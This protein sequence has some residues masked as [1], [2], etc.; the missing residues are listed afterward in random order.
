MQQADDFLAES[1]SLF[2]L[3][4][5]LDDD[6]LERVTAFK[7]WRIANVIAHLSV[8]NRAAVL[9]L[10]DTDALSALLRGIG[11]HLKAG[12]RMTEFEKDC[13]EGVWGRALVEHWWRSCEETARHFAVADP[14]QR[15]PWAGP[16]MS[17]RSSISARL[18]ETWAHGQEVFDELGVVRANADRIYNIA[19]LGNNTYGWTFKNRGEQPPEPRPFLELVAPS[20]KVWTFNEPRDDERISGSAEAFCQVVTQVRNIADTDLEVSGA[21]AEAWMSRA[22]CFAGAPN[23]PPAPG[24]RVIR[25]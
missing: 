24:T 4:A 25:C 16:D 17:A 23:D 21:N 7:G 12:G 19:V 14:A 1:R 3:V 11:E 8:W 10:T 18:M 6:A 5:P 20:G 9:S 15:V 22:Q 13:H 2:E